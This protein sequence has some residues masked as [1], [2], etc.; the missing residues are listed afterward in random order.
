MSAIIYIEKDDKGI[1]KATKDACQFAKDL[2]TTI[3][4]GFSSEILTEKDVKE[5]GEFG[6]SKIYTS[7]TN[8]EA[9]LSSITSAMCKF[10]EENKSTNIVFPNTL[11]GSAIAAKMA[12]KLNA[13]IVTGVL[14]SPT[15]ENETATIKKG[16]YTGKAFS[17]VSTPLK[18]SI[19]VLNKGVYNDYNLEKTE[20]E[21]IVLDIGTQKEES[22]FETLATIKV[23]GDV[24]LPDA[25]KV[26]SAGR[27]LKGAENWG[28]IE[29][30]AKLLGAATAC[31]KPVSDADWRPHHEH[32]GQTGLKIAP[33]LY[34]AIG[35]S[36]AI[37]H[38]AGVSNSD[39]IVV[40]NT[41]AD[42]PFFKAADYGIVGDA[43]EIVP[44]LISALE[45]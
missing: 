42:A 4:L 26:V 45:K 1:K 6:L 12:I 14:T 10:F 43:F 18:H 34:I 21:V 23:E 17:L 24:L 20:P 27:G 36:G 13:S 2:K 44:K 28:M 16:N 15:I 41:D 3:L 33:K 9:N 25:E 40:I 37:Q 19:F 11:K 39:T 35:I 38:L 30:L 7:N 32:V 22:N 31:S 8:E 5:L 29:N